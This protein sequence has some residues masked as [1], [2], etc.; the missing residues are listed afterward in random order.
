[1]HRS[2]NFC[3]QVTAAIHCLHLL[4]CKRTVQYDV[5]SQAE[6][7]CVTRTMK[8]SEAEEEAAEEQRSVL[9]NPAGITEDWAQKIQIAKQAR[10]AGKAIRRGD[11]PPA[12]QPPAANTLLH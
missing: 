12:P 11:K 4:R 10:E 3:S 7:S 8:D 9:P 6:Y 5:G 1:M 2:G